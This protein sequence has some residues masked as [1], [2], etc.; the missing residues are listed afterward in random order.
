[1]KIHTTDFATGT[2]GT[3]DQAARTECK[4]QDMFFLRKKTGGG[5]GVFHRFF[6]TVE[7]V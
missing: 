4:P 2:D 6:L 1:M 5:K 7:A 3:V